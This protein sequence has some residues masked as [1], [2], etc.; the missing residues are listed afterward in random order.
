[1]LIVITH[2]TKGEA[3]LP[4]LQDFLLERAAVCYRAMALFNDTAFLALT[5]SSGARALLGTIEPFHFHS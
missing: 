3:A 4:Q 5:F 1:M 2:Q